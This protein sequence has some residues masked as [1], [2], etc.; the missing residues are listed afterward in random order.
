MKPRNCCTRS[1]RRKRCGGSALA[2][3]RVRA[4]A[5]CAIRGGTSAEAGPVPILGEPAPVA[6]ALELVRLRLRRAA[7]LAAARWAGASVGGGLAGVVGGAVGGMHTRGGSRQRGFARSR[8]GVGRHRRVLRGRR[9][10]GSRRGLSVAESIARSRRAACVRVR[11]GSRRRP[12]G[13]IAQWLGRWSL[14]RSSASTSI[15]AEASKDSS[16]GR[17]PG[18]ATACARRHSDGGLA[19]PRGRKRLR[20]AGATAAACGVAALAL[21]ACRPAAGR[22][23]DSRDRPGVARIAG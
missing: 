3:T 6:T 20:A 7:A 13:V 10:C 16:S 1:E 19:A 2:R 18:L 14:R 8:P 12:G 4:R 11:R 22:R 9:R 15:S 17:R 5:C 23:H 21:D